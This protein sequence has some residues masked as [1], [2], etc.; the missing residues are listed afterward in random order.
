MTQEF[1]GKVNIGRTLKPAVFQSNATAEANLVK[2]KAGVKETAGG[3]GA[4]DSGKPMRLTIQLDGDTADLR[5]GGSGEAGDIRLFSSKDS[6]KPSV[7][8]DGEAGDIKLMGAD[9]AEGFRINE[10]ASRIEPGTVMVIGNDGLLQ[11]S[12]KAYDRRVAGIVSG[13]GQYKPG[14]ILGTNFDREGHVAIAL[15]GKVFCNVDARQTPIEVGDLLTTSD[16]PGYAM[17]ASIPSEAFGAVLGKALQA[18]KEGQGQ[19]PV[20]ISLQ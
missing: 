6:L 1:S 2:P 13:A 7:H 9:C 16:H 12:Y 15:I 8:L 3:V 20:L 18:L 10:T 4:T 14:I 5:V 11:Q 19:I 17:K